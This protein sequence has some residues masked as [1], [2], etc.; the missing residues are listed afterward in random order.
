M[1]GTDRRADGQTAGGLESVLDGG[2]ESSSPERHS[3]YG[4]GSEHKGESSG[5]LQMRGSCEGG[6]MRP[7]GHV[8]RAVCISAGLVGGYWLVVVCVCVCVGI[9]CWHTIKRDGNGALLVEC[10]CKWA[11]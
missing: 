4:A 1:G 10:V 9:V 5:M 6:R 3:E 7:G 11:M 8:W 2:L